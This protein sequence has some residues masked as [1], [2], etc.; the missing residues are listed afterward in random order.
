MA[1]ATN[2]LPQSTLDTFQ[3]ISASA[4]HILA[5]LAAKKAVKEQLRSEG[6]RMT[7][8]LPAEINTKA[9]AYLALHSELLD[10]ARERAVKMGMFDNPKRRRR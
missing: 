9:A 8:V 6:R 5:R 4:V 10:E 2:S 7:L 3:P 1:K